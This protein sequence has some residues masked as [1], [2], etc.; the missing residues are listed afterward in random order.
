MGRIFFA[1]TLGLIP[2]P[3]FSFSF[4]NKNAHFNFESKSN[5]FFIRCSFV[6]T[7][8]RLKAHA[9]TSTQTEQ[10]HK[11]GEWVILLDFIFLRSFCLLPIPLGFFSSFFASRSVSL[12]SQSWYS[13]VSA[14]VIVLYFLQHLISNFLSFTPHR[15]RVTFRIPLHS[16][17]ALF[18]FFCR[19]F[20]SL[21]SLHLHFCAS[22]SM[23]TR[24]R[25]LFKRRSD[26]K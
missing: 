21:L 1:P 18:L 19:F 20:F 17:R 2:H 12:A 24:W 16:H 22:Q 7:R 9:S 11:S 10:R 4:A 25:T 6:R 26:R 5:F 14:V 13:L 3:N 15:I 8:K 23:C